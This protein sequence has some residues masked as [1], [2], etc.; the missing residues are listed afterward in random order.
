MNK[1]FLWNIFKTKYNYYG[2]EIDENIYNR[3]K[4]CCF[5]RLPNQRKWKKQDTEHI[6]L[7]FLSFFIDLP[8]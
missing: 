7:L 1:A 4:N 8:L 2:N 6:L 5:L 3:D